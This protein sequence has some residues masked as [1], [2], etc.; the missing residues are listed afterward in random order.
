MKHVDERGCKEAEALFQPYLLNKLNNKD[1]SFLLDHIEHCSE[2]ADELEIHYLM[3]EGLKRLENGETLDLK[4]ELGRKLE[5][6]RQKVLF[7]ERL[8]AGLFL[9]EG[10]VLLVILSQ[11]ILV[12]VS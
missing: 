12:W 1:I 9:V 4:G 8:K 11:I 2:C 7:L 3:Q 6:S 5:K 10:T